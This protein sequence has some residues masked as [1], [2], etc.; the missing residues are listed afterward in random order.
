MLL[1]AFSVSAKSRTIE[2]GCILLLLLSPVLA[3]AQSPLV[4]H[5]PCEDAANPVDASD[6]PA[7]VVVHGSLGS[8][9]GQFGTMALEF[10]GDNANR[11]EV[12]SA[13][14]LEGM[15]ALTVEAWVM[16]RNLADQGNIRRRQVGDGPLGR[17]VHVEAHDV[18]YRPGVIRRPVQVDRVAGRAGCHAEV[19]DGRRRSGGAHV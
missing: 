15:S 8:V 10:D 2:W 1:S 12:P 3:T 19:V 16:P 4:L 14:K 17:D 18:S 6:D 7:T 11:I 5:L 13:A 9:D